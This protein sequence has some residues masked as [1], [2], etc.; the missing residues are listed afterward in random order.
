M[1]GSEIKSF[2]HHPHFKKELNERA[3]E[4]Y[5]SFQ[6][7]PGFETFFKDVYKMPPAHYFLY[8]DGK[9]S[10][11]RYWIP[12]FRAEEDKTLEYWVDEIEKTFDDS[13]E[14]HKIK[15]MKRG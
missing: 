3:L 2:L 11:T 5:L 4:S 14:A 1:F 15:I 13:V 7:S 6:Y 12:E 10:L 8:K 9:M